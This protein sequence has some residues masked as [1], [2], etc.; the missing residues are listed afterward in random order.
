M[1]TSF[2]VVVIVTNCVDLNLQPILSL[3]VSLVLLQKF[4]VEVKI[5]TKLCKDG[6]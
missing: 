4:D 6:A 5:Y 1:S 3:F 2:D